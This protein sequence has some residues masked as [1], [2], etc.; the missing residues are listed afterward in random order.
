MGPLRFLI[1]TQPANNCSEDLENWF[2]ANKLTLNLGKTSWYMP[3]EEYFA[4]NYHCNVEIEKAPT[5]KM[6]ISW[7]LS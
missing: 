7:Y 1:Y 3:L 6:Q 4:L 5:C 2:K